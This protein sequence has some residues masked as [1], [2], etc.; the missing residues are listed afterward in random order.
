[1][2]Q[3]VWTCYY[4]INFSVI[5]NNRITEY[6]WIQSTNSFTTVTLIN[7]GGYRLIMQT[8]FQSISPTNTPPDILFQHGNRALQSEEY[9]QAISYFDMILLL[10]PHCFEALYNKGSCAH[11]P[12]Y[13]Y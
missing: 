9:Q 12:A 1:M 7:A 10:S 11:F 6:D 8:S 2:N 4:N 3:Q 13:I 5:K